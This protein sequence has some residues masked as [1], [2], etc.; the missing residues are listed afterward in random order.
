MQLVSERQGPGAD[1]GHDPCAR[2][3]R[4][5]LVV[6][7][8]LL[9]EGDAKPQPARDPTLEGHVGESARRVAG[10][11]DELVPRHLE[12]AAVGRPRSD[13]TVLARLDVGEGAGVDQ[14]HGEHR[15]P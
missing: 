2:P 9:V 12:Q 6:Q 5:S 13:H 10:R 15:S 14:G 4:L 8:H 11:R 1:S 7:V 3:L